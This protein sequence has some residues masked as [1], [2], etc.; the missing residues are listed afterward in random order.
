MGELAVPCVRTSLVLG[1]LL[2]KA[3]G[4]ASVKLEAGV[5]EPVVRTRLCGQR[6]WPK[7]SSAQ[8]LPKFPVCAVGL[9]RADDPRMFA[10]TLQV[11][12][13]GCSAVSS[14]DLSPCHICN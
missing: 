11:A 13:A 3:E 7:C 10:E 2:G 14:W 4:S 6:S 8:G 5:A 1:L 9:R 12:R